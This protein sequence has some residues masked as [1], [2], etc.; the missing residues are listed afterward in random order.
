MCYFQYLLTDDKII[1]E[2]LEIGTKPKETGNTS[3]AGQ[4]LSTAI[5]IIVIWG[6][7]VIKQADLVTNVTIHFASHSFKNQIVYNRTVVNTVLKILY[8]IQSIK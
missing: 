5:F 2:G 6:D 1:E 3:M 7:L 8:K 4:N